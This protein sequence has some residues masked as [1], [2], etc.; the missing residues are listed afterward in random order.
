MAGVCVVVS[1]AGVCV[2]VVSVAFVCVCVVGGFFLTSPW[3]SVAF[4]WIGFEGWLFGGFILP[5]PPAMCFNE[6]LCVPWFTLFL[7]PSFMS[8]VV[9]VRLLL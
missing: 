4:L 7:T 9:L 8:S 2:I 6:A 5:G 1:V 3:A